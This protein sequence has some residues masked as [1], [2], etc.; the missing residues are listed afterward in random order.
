M[1]ELKDKPTKINTFNVSLDDEVIARG[2]VGSWKK[3]KGSRAYV[4]TITSF[5]T[6]A[7]NL[8][9]GVQYAVTYQTDGKV[10][11]P[12]HDT[13][14]YN[15]KSKQGYLFSTLNKLMH[16]D[17]EGQEVIPS[18]HLSHFGILGYG[19]NALENKPVMPIVDFTYSNPEQ[20]FV[21]NGEQVQVPD[22]ID[23]SETPS[24]STIEEKFSSK[25]STAREFQLNLKAKVGL[26]VEDPET[27]LTFSG[28]AKAANELFSQNKGSWALNVYYN[29]ADI[30]FIKL[31][32]I[33]YAS[34]LVPDVVE[35]IEACGTDPERIADFY[36]TYG[37]HVLNSAHIGGQLNIKTSLRIDSKS[38]KEI[39]TGSIN[40]EGAVKSEND[41]YINGKIKFDERDEHTS[42]IY[43]DISNTQILLIGGDVTTKDEKT[44][45]RSLL[46]SNVPT[47]SAGK[48]V[49]GYGVAGAADHTGNTNLGLVL[50]QYVEIYK[51]LG[52][53]KAQEEAFEEVFNTHMNGQ[54][55]FDNTPQRLIPEMSHD[56]PI[57]IAD[58]EK[59]KAKGQ[60][61]PNRQT[62]EMRGWMATYVTKAGLYGKPGSW[63]DVSCKSDA[64]PGG[65]TTKR[66]YA[67]EELNLRDKTPYLSKYM[68]IQVD[69]YGGDNEAVVY[70]NNQMV[71]W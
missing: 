55:P 33:D 42:K 9:I 8:E 20:A 12:T 57:S 3:N 64:E 17:E 14:Y 30:S 63:A 69:T 32:R 53:G 7:E 62:F 48:T 26:S 16:D 34:S 61:L 66:I 4:Y 49:H 5:R 35:A 70:T 29:R 45:R 59:A 39:S 56:H 58:I 68:Y 21:W 24:G 38:N 52:L 25:I 19:I 22:Q 13:L 10:G 41:D 11:P 46:K 15:K 18:K 43:R 60:A 67:G 2:G 50:L 27:D 37:T 47:R 1:E 65:W 40:I 31:T 44:W 28:E 54:N 23:F 51:M 6:G 71:S 36:D